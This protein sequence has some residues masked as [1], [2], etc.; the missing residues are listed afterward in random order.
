MARVLVLEDSETRIAWFKRALIGHNATFVENV[1][2]AI[3]A[4]GKMNWDL[5]CLDH[6]LVPEHYGLYMNDDDEVY[7]R[8]MSRVKPPTGFRFAEWLSGSNA[9]HVEPKTKVL[10]HTLNPAG[11]K[12]MKKFLPHA[13]V[14]N[15]ER[16]KKLNA[17]A[18]D[19]ISFLLE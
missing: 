6:D 2:D 16:L 1:A 10:I 9:M 14:I 13:K 18:A 12:A 5:I 17:N 7:R 11:Q 19:S 3:S 4:C 8:E 15:F